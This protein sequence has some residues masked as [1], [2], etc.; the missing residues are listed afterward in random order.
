MTS[1]LRTRT[2]FA[3]IVFAVS[4]AA[5]A[6]DDAPIWSVSGY[7]TLGVVHSSDDEADYIA[8]TFLPNG[9]GHTRDWSADVDSRFAL[10]VTANVTPKLSAV[11]QFISEQRFDGS[12]QPTTEWAN[13]IYR[14]TPDFNVR[15]GRFVQPTFLFADTRN[16]AY[17][18][19]WVRPPTELYDLVPVT[20][21]DGIGVF[22]RM[23]LGGGVI[24]TL[25]ASYGELDIHLPDRLGDGDTKARDSISLMSTTEY[26]AATLRISY[27]QVDL[28]VEEFG[29]LFDAFR[30][31]GPEG[32]AI[33]N[34]YDVDGDR[35]EFVGV[36][37]NYDPG[38]WFAIGEWGAIDSHNVLGKS[39]AWYL[40]GGYRFGTFTPYV[41][42]ARLNYRDMTSDPGLTL[43][44]LPP[45]LAGAGAGLNG[46]LNGIL[47]GAAGQKTVTLGLR[48]D[49]MR[50]VAF[51]AQYEFIDRD[52]GSPGTFGNLQPG[53]EPGGDAG[54]FSASLNV[55]F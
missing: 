17:T 36:G 29:L 34:R 40:S 15:V 51:K 3:V 45:P 8:E 46:A 7:G 12:Y 53:F 13:L 44:S 4:G 31:F 50:N 49:F 33:A 32:V 16:V 35:A 55:V 42:Y 26:G 19:P 52:D 5:V 30:Q 10:Q 27:H 1:R 21:N 37:L 2:I 6:G 18:Y 38:Q 11:V 43:S 28:T 41:A 48:W 9:P 39:D 14:F 20:H 54:L 23:Q 47:A 22:Y 24:E 25:E